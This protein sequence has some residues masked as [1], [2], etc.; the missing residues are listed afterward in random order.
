L[1]GQY[2]SAGTPPRA[3]AAFTVNGKLKALPEEFSVEVLFYNPELFDQAGIAYPGSHW[4]WD[5]LEADT[6]ALTSLGL[7]DAKGKSDLRDR[8]PGQLRSLEHPLRGGRRARARPRRLAPHR[9]PAR[10]PHR[11]TRCRSCT[12]C[13]SSTPSRRPWARA[14]RCSGSTSRRN[15]PR[16]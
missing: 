14:R 15:A 10:R 7:K 2:A 13:S 11:C 16:C 8:A 3:T 1:S 4:N 6:R 5:M 12:T 9:L